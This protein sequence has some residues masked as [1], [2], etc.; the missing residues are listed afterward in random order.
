MYYTYILFSEKDNKLYAG[1]TPDLKQRI[2]KH[3]NG[4]VR[5]TKF[6]R[7]L[8]LIYYESYLSKTDARKREVYLKGGKG[9][10]ELKIQLSD[11]Y[12]QIDYK[13]RL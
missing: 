7:P 1:Y 5:A 9:K 8:K 11:T 12:K 2:D 10:S 13:Q 3:Q 4:F 6:R